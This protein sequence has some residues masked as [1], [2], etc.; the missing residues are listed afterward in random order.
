MKFYA[1]SGNWA[2]LTN[3]D[4]FQVTTTNYNLSIPF[5]EPNF[6]IGLLDSI[7]GC[8]LE[9]ACNY[10]SISIINDTSC[11]FP[12]EYYNCIDECIN[13]DDFDG[14][15]DENEVFGCTDELSLNYSI[16]ATEN[17]YSCVS[18][19]FGCTDS[20]SVNY[21]DTANVDDGSCLSVEEYT[22]DS[23]ETELLTLNEEAT[24]SLSSLQQALDTWNTTI[25]LSA[26]WNM[27]GYGCPSPIDIAEGLSNHTESINIVKDNNGSVYMPEF[28]FN[29]IGDFTPGFGYQIKVTEAIE[30]FSLCDWYVNDIPED[31]IVSLQEE[32]V[33]LSEENT[34]LQE[35][36]DSLSTYGC[37]DET[38]FNYNP[39]ANM[40]DGSCQFIN[41]FYPPDPE[42]VSWLQENT[43][44]VMNGDCMDIN[45][46][47]IVEND[48]YIGNTSIIN[49]DGLQYFT[50]LWYLDIYDNDALTS[51]PDL[52]QLNLEMLIISSNDLLLSLPNVSNV[53]IY[54][55]NNNDAL[56]IVPDLSE[57][58]IDDLYIG[59]NNSL[60][61]VE[62]YPQILIDLLPAD[63]FVSSL[64]PVCSNY[65]VGDFAEGGIIFYVDEIGQHG[66]VAALQDLGQFEWGCFWENVEGADETSI[67]TGYQNTM[68]IIYQGC[69]TENG[70]I[71]GAQ[72]AS[73]YSDFQNYSNWFLPSY[74]ELIELYNFVYSFPNYISQ[75]NFDS[76]QYYWS[77]SEAFGNNNKDAYGL[78]FS[79]GGHGPINKHD[80]LTVRP[81][82]S[83]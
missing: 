59:N 27:F 73:S 55:I 35:L 30:G 46:A 63:Y 4:D 53:S 22:I 69:E 21:S 66:L 71:T 3:I 11:Y 83:F 67:G 79:D 31:N 9:G 37:I 49:L 32:V 34:S 5:I 6:S 17:D 51:I 45:A 64:P 39:S 57:V 44:G 1:Y 82:R 25:D 15:C 8:T 56:I 48:L 62:G 80:P 70:G 19:I 16:S 76:N 36:V 65:E 47:A 38:A 14:V 18:A 28:G 54:Q 40:D 81:I 43:E 10:D 74:D 52:S 29:G 13:D 33:S 24:T 50:N 61:C 42:F 12:L 72:A 26:G 68:D 7:Y 23:L 20:I 60:V 77:S 78:R 75:Y 41:C 58:I 2:I